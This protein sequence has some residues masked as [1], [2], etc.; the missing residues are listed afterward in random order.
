MFKEAGID[1]PDTDTPYTWDDFVNVSKQLTKDKDGDGKMDQ[2]A[3]GFNVNWS[4]QAFVWSN[5]GDWINEDK[6]TVT[7]DT[8]EFA[9]ALQWFADLQ[10]VHELTPSI[11]D[12]QTLDTYQR[13]MNGEI[14]FF[15]VGP[16]DMSTYAGLDFEYDLIP[17][18]AGSTGK[19]ATYVGSL[20]IG[21]ASKTDYPDEAVKLVEYLSASEDGQQQLVDAQI[22]IPNL[23]DMAEE[24]ASDTESVPTNKQEFL[25]LSLIHI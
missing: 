15:P 22:Q 13:W 2:W 14:A 24:W 23:I 5:G 11:S 19:S 18:P 25:D 7:V 4:L 1:L 10:N 8:P 20:G 16:W 3:T 12:A 6:D 17:W 21:V 9:E